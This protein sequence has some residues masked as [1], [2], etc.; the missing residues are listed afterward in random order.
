QRL[1]RSRVPVCVCHLLTAVERDALAADGAFIVPVLHNA[2]AG[3]LEDAAA[4][5]GA[6]HVIA[7]SAAAAADLRREGCDAAVS[8]IRH[9]PRP[10]RFAPGARAAWRRSWRVPA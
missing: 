2:R 9:I 1:A 10:R 5:R 6:R 3:W 4:L 7:V 8:V